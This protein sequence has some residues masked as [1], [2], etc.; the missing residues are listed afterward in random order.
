MTD[1]H[2]VFPPMGGS[3]RI[4]YHADEHE[5]APILQFDAYPPYTLPTPPG[6]VR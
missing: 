2:D 1:W 3:F 5:P 6:Q 4:R